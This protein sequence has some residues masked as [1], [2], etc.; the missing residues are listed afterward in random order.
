MVEAGELHP[1]LPAAGRVL[2][3]PV[4]CCLM[5]DAYLVSFTCVAEGDLFQRWF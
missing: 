4:A 3:L 2:L 5:P 1:L